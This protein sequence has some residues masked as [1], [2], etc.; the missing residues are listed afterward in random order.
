MN[1]APYLANERASFDILRQLRELIHREYPDGGCLP[2]QTTMCQRLGVSNKTYLKAIQYLVAD[3]SV[4][5]GRGR[6][7]MRVNPEFER[8]KK[9]GI[10]LHAGKESPFIQNGCILSALIARLTARGYCAQLLQSSTP[11][12]IGLKALQH[13]AR[14]IV[15]LIP[16][17]SALSAI[18]RLSQDFSQLLVMEGKEPVLQMTI[19]AS[20]PTV[21]ARQEQALELVLQV[22]RKH[23]KGN[24]VCVGKTAGVHTENYKKIPLKKRTKFYAAVCIEPH[25]LVSRLLDTVTR[26]GP[27]AIYAGGGGAVYRPLL[28]LLD[29][30]PQP[31][32]PLVIADSASNYQ[33]DPQVESTIYGY[34]EPMTENIGVTAADNLIHHLEKSAPLQTALLSCFRF[35]E[36]HMMPHIRA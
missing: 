6:I 19:D 22:L 11:E 15:W 10:V 21:A 7:G 26:T 16:P 24:L 13:G 30:L 1:K 25:K 23:G 3:G 29:R 8:P 20:L 12:K 27:T 34:I 36:N 32:R 35:V 4:K 9:I 2:N 14:A 18:Q 31:Q 17:E 5:A 28:R 33:P